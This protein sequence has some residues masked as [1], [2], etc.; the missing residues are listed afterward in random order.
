MTEFDRTKMKDTESIDFFS[1]RLTEISSKS[2]ALG[3]SIEE[4]KL[5][6]KF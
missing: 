3:E 1:G 6:K 5:V 2:T 4:S